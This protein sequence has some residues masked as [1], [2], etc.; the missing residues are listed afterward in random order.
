[1]TRLMEASLEWPHPIYIRLAKGG[2]PTISSD[3]RGFRIGRAIDMT[4]GGA[5]EVLIVSTGVATTRALEAVESLE[6]SGPSCRVLHMHTVKPLDTDS[7]IDAA[8]DAR[9]VLTVEEHTV[10][11]GL[12]SAVCETLSDGMERMPR[13]RRLGIPD[14]FSENYGSQNELM[15]AVGIDAAGIRAAIEGSSPSS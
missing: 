11:G 14:R 8:R 6:G 2:D 15:A 9:L 10:L 4:G 3:E 13:V 12:G 1:M 5:A 7:L